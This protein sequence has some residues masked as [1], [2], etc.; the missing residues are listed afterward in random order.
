MLR[1]IL[2]FSM[3]ITLIVF[4][5]CEEKC[6]DDSVWDPRPEP[7][8]GVFS[9]TGDEYV[10]LWWAGPYDRDID[11]FIIYANTVGL[12]ADYVEIGR[13]SAD[14][15]PNVDLI[16]YDFTHSNLDN[17]DT[18]Y[19]AIASVDNAGQISTLSAEDI[20]DTPRPEGVIYIYDI[21]VIQSSAGIHFV[22]GST[23]DAA[24]SECDAYIDSFDGIYYLNAGDLNLF[25]GTEI[26]GMGYTTY[27]D[28]IGYAPTTGWSDLGYVEV[29]I[30]HTYIIKTDDNHYAK[31]RVLETDGAGVR[32]QWAYQTDLNNPELIA[33]SGNIDQNE[34]YIYSKKK[35]SSKGSK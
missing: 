2:L 7:P 4:A 26:Q 22:A 31:M 18:Y 9:I 10:E 24:N 13:R 16:Y 17:G 23:I 5:G 32:L 33:P 15:N 25:R 11:E 30:G 34:S 6:D 27:W 3:M 28:D 29:V 19:Y 14:D 20:F 12:N 35:E 21:N 1:S 8:Q